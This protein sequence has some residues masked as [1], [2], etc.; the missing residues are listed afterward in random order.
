MTWQT[1]CTGYPM[2]CKE[3]PD[4]A[5]STWRNLTV[6]AA[7]KSFETT[8]VIRHRNHVHSRPASIFFKASSNFLMSAGDNC[9]RSTLMVTLLSVAVNGNGGL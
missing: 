7:P 1:S 3:V 4:E 2:G 5:L 8:Q 6:W 9:G